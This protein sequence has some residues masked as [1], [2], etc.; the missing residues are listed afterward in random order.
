MHKQFY[1]V[2]I[3][4]FTLANGASGRAAKYMHYFDTPMPTGLLKVPHRFA[5]YGALDVG[6]LCINA[7]Q[8]DHDFLA[9][10]NDVYQ[11]PVNIDTDID[12]VEFNKLRA[13][14]RGVKIPA[15][16]ILVNQPY[17]GIIR[18]ILKACNIMQSFNGKFGGSPL[19]EAGLGS[20]VSELT[21]NQQA[22]LQSIAIGLNV[23]SPLT[24]NM[25][26]ILTTLL[27][28]FP[29]VNTRK[30]RSIRISHGGIEL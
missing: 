16:W 15:K 8:V 12:T 18:N 19:G 7:E 24:G 2:P 27:E 17:K 29:S 11:F 26:D 13:L 9:A 20:L 10:K 5:D 6:L 22:G 28:A 1:V 4:N 3:S 14:L 21:T 25:E 23:S 30:G